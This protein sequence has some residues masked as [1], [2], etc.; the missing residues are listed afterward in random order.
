MDSQVKKGLLE[1]YILSKLSRE[2]SY[3]YQMIKDLADLVEISEST[4]YPI[5][6]RLEGGGDVDTYS[7]EYNSRIRRYYRI[8]QKGRERLAEFNREQWKL[9]KILRY[10]EGKEEG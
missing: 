7:R 6:R 8:T 3:G 10:I 2:E 9:R 4:L 1:F 5:L